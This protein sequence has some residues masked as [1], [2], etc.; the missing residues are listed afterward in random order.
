[1]MKQNEIQKQIV[2]LIKQIVVMV[3]DGIF[4]TDDLLC[5][6]ILMYMYGQ[7]NV[8][9]IRSRNKDDYEKANFILDVGNKNE[10]TN[11]QIWFDHHED[12]SLKE[13]HENGIMM[14]ACGKLARY[15]NFPKELWERALYSVEAQDNGQWEL[16]KQYPNPFSFVSSFNVDWDKPLYG[17]E[18]DAA[19][20]EAV[21]MAY[22]VFVKIMDSIELESM[23]KAEVEKALANSNNTIVELPQYIGGWQKYI[24]QYNEVNPNDQKLLIIFQSGAN[25]NV[26]VVPE[27]DEFGSPSIISLPEKWAGLRD[28]ALDE[29]TG[30]ANGVFVHPARF[31]GIWTS[32]ESALQAAK[33]AIEV[34]KTT[35]KK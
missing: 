14:A 16:A 29:V 13:Y 35:N 17:K 22:K 1:M 12:N 5:I 30:I 7:E 4:H 3:H 28:G 6:V 21:E 34:A 10:V 15:F 2:E 26:Q 11:G 19:F 18:Q 33:V 32:K 20:M 31:M 25:F 23:A 8:S 24:C 27:K 9:I